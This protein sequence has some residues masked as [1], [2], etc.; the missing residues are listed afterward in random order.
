V[1]RLLDADH[2]HEPV[3]LV[4]VRIGGRVPLLR[5]L[6]LA[7]ERTRIAGPVGAHDRQRA[8]LGSRRDAL[9]TAVPVSTHGYVGSSW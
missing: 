1:G 3:A 4:A 9:Q 2:R 8:G 5:V 6:D 7:V